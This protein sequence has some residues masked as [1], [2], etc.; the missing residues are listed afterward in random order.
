MQNQEFLIYR[1]LNASQAAVYSWL[2]ANQP[3]KDG[4]I[5]SSGR[6]ELESALLLRDEPLVKLGLALFGYEQETGI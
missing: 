2:E 5:F 1:L 6:E 4:S 3:K